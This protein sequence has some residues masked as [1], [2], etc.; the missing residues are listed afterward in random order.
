MIWASITLAAAVYTSIVLVAGFARYIISGSMRTKLKSLKMQDP[1]LQDMPDLKQ[2][3][4]IRWTPIVVAVLWGV[5]F[6]LTR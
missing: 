2:T 4:P 1:K 5:F 6:Y 3:S